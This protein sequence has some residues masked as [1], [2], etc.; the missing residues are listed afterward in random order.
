MLE[1]VEAAEGP[2]VNARCTLRGGPCRWEGRC[3]VHD[4]WMKAGEAL[5]RSLA[6][7]NL[8]R[9]ANADLAG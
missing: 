3:A 1:V 9:V 4:T 8:A 5:R 6:G 7:T 2:L